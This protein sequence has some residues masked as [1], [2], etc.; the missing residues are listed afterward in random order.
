MANNGGAIAISGDGTAVALYGCRFE[1]NAAFRG[2]AVYLESGRLHIAGCLF[3]NNRALLRGTQA[4]GEDRPS[5]GALFVGAQLGVKGL[6]TVQVD[7]CQFTENTTTAHTHAIIRR[8]EIAMNQWLVDYTD[9]VKINEFNEVISMDSNTTWSCGGAIYTT[10]NVSLDVSERAPLVSIFD[11][12]NDNDALMAG[13]ALCLKNDTTAVLTGSFIKGNRAVPILDH[14][15]G[16]VTPSQGGAIYC[17]ACTVSLPGTVVSGNSEDALTDLDT[18]SSIACLEAIE[19]EPCLTC[20]YCQRCFTGGQIL[21]LLCGQYAE[22]NITCQPGLGCVTQKM[23]PARPRVLH[24]CRNHL[25]HPWVEQILPASGP[26]TGGPEVTLVGFFGPP[27]SLL[28][29]AFGSSPCRV[30]FAS[31]TLIRCVPAAGAQAGLAEVQISTATSA[32][33]SAA[34]FLFI[35]PTDVTA[36]ANLTLS[37]FL[38]TPNPATLPL[39]PPFTPSYHRYTATAPV[40]LVLL[41]P[42]PQNPTATVRVN[43]GDPARPVRLAEGTNSI[44]VE[45]Q[46]RSGLSEEYWVDVDYAGG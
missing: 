10:T 16:A 45:V 42:T 28:A 6:I 3:V 39:S 11:K 44:L 2:G 9:P 14:R 31:P 18:I 21:P 12:N 46:T 30:T 37:L 27:D 25:S 33:L 40:P 4:A 35:D 7:D 13:G 32:V 43:L 34:R 19:C 8:T 23:V 5:G 26:L 22:L 36:L 24:T 17:L 38:P 1:S 20:S 41:S 29:V 15:S